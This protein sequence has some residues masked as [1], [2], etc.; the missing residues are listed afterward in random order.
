MNRSLF[1]AF[2]SIL[3]AGL[4][5][6]ST[7]TS[8]SQ[9]ATTASAASTKPT[10]TFT[11]D[12][13]VAQTTAQRYGGLDATISLLADQWKKVNSQFNGDGRLQAV[14]QFSVVSSHQYADDAPSEVGRLH[15]STN[16]KV[17]YDEDTSMTF[18]WNRNEQTIVVKPFPGT[19][20]ILGSDTTDGVV[21]ELGHYRGAVDEYAC[22]ITEPPKNPVNGWTFREI[23]SIMSVSQKATSWSPYAAGLINLQGSRKDEPYPSLASTALPP[24]TVST[25]TNAFRTPVQARVRMYPVIW[26]S[27]QVNATPSQ[28]VQ[29]NKNGHYTFS[30]NPF[31]ADPD[32]NVPWN[33]R[34]CLLLVRAEWNGKVNYS[35]LPLAAVGGA[36]FNSRTKPYVHMINF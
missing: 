16:V 20:G 13:A 7:T 5:V 21:H 18:G 2:I 25:T 23:P 14:Y 3:A 4:L 6:A 28:Q 33:L 1:R 8:V 15:P 10:Y 29:T 35:W 9:A 32:I 12:I 27:G 19:G 22:N 34:Y 36:Y 24:L 17:I 26:Y 31:T 30:V 11:V